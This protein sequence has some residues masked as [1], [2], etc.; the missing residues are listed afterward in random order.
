VFRK[1][2]LEVTGCLP[3]D[4]KNHNDI[5]DGMNDWLALE[6]GDRWYDRWGTT[7]RLVGNPYGDDHAMFCKL[8]RHFRAHP[9]NNAC[10]YTHYVR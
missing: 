3:D 8:C 10:L 6:P 9:V 5:A 2:C 7:H 1:S 4:W